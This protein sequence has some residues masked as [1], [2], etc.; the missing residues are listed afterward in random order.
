MAEA[1]ILDPTTIERLG[2]ESGGTG[3]AVVDSAGGRLL[4]LSPAAEGLRAALAQPDGAIRADLPALGRLRALAAGAA[5]R[6][7]PRPE[8]LRLGRLAPPIPCR[9]RLASLDG[10]EDVLLLAFD[11]NPPAAPEKHLPAALPAPLAAPAQDPADAAATAGIAAFL[12]KGALPP[13][14]VGAGEP[15]PPPPPG[16]PS[17]DSWF[18][19]IRDLVTETLSSARS[20]LKPHEVLPPSPTALESPTP[21]TPPEREA[22]REAEIAEATAEPEAGAP[23]EPAEAAAP[24]PPAPAEEPARLGAGAIPEAMPSEEAVAAAAEGEPALDAEEPAHEEPDPAPRPA[25]ASPLLPEPPAPPPLQGRSAAPGLTSAERS[26]FREIA[27]ALGARF[28]D[29]PMPAAPPPRVPAAPAPPAPSPAPPKAQNSANAVLD[30]VPAG[31]IVH[32]GD[33]ILFANR[34]LLDLVSFDAVGQIAAEGGMKRLFRSGPAPVETGPG[35][36]PAVLA[37]RRN[38]NLAVVVSSGPATWDGAPATLMLIRQEEAADPSPDLRRAEAEAASAAGRAR[39]L[40]AILD[41]ATDGVLVLDETRPHP[42]AQPL[43]GSACSA[44]T[45]ARSRASR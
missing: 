24:Q 34:L 20:A 39:E 11:A 29:D 1:S 16:P 44:T 9:C 4:Y 45:S 43:G 25:A 19:S 5:P 2:R 26:A 3:F 38:Y 21:G 40:E 32:R 14:A 7:E 28:A 31:V 22:P 13:P 35:G 42:F 33:E 8:R 23:E 15:A 30:A 18:A 6:D 41:T 10:G 12:S 37:T 17:E 27:R 36:A